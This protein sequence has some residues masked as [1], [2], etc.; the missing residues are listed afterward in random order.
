MQSF[1]P[2]A[3]TALTSPQK[4][5]EIH[6]RRTSRS[7]LL[8]CTFASSQNSVWGYFVRLGNACPIFHRRTLLWQSI[9]SIVLL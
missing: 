2:Q 7:H 3:A 6:S 4:M 5:T 8:V 1:M 9:Q